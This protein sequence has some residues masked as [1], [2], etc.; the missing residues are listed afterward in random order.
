LTAVGPPLVVLGASLTV[1][2]I[3][4]TN[5]AVSEVGADEKGL[6]SGIFETSNHLLGG[7]VGVTVYAAIF[8]TFSGGPRDSAGYRAAFL[9]AA[10][11]V[12]CLAA[13]SLSQTRARA[14]VPPNDEPAVP[15]SDEP[16][17]SAS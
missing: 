7:T 8:S 1:V 5:Q 6:A 15:P 10:G 12:V 13:L 17:H 16:S 3:V 2:F 9:A 14:H 4:T 11:I